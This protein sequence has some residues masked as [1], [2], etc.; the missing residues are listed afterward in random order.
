VLPDI[1]SEPCRTYALE[2]GKTFTAGVYTW[3]SS[4]WIDAATNI[5]IKGTLHDRFVFQMTGIFFVGAGAKVVLIGDGTG[6]GVPQVANIVWQVAQYVTV[7][8]AAHVSGILLAAEH[9]EF[10]AVSTHVG[11]IFSQTATTLI[12]TTVVEQDPLIVEDIPPIPPPPPSPPSPPLSPPPPSP[13]PLL[14]P[15]PSPANT[16]LA[17]AAATASSRAATCAVSVG[18][19]DLVSYANLVVQDDSFSLEKQLMTATAMVALAVATITIFLRYRRLRGVAPAAAV[20]RSSTLD[21]RVLP[22]KTPPRA[23]ILP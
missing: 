5:Y 3:R 18:E 6:Q 10:E 9:C 13:P 12:M 23:V 17:A 20:P 1:H 22:V 21:Q 14:L 15:P 7:S 4:V 2:G 11:R 8:T 16:A 19:T